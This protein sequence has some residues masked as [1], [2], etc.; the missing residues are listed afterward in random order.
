MC[1]SKLDSDVVSKVLTV[2]V[3]LL[4]KW[5]SNTQHN[6][7]KYIL[8]TRNKEQ[9]RIFRIFDVGVFDIDLRGY[10][11]IQHVSRHPDESI[12]IIIPRSS[13]N[14]LNHSQ[15]CQNCKYYLADQRC[16]DLSR[17]KVG[18]WPLSR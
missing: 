16:Q 17:D 8:I 11:P 1:I 9:C 18:R 7:R 4:S 3:D 2:L 12:N 10:V 13:P 15:L 5:W 14:S 6:A